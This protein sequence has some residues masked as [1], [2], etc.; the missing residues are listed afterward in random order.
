[1]IYRGE[2]GYLELL[3]DV[4]ALGVDI[5]DR[6]GVGCRAL[7]DA[8]W[9]IEKG[10]PFSTVRPAA[11]RLAF[12]EFW[13]FLRGE[14]QTKK[15]EDKGVM[16]WKGNTSRE[17]LDQRGLYREPEGDMGL[18]YGFQFRH[19]GAVRFYHEPL[20]PV[21][22]GGYDQLENLIK[23]LQDDRY[24]RRHYVTFWNPRDS[25][26]MSL[27]PCWH[28][29]QFVVL[30]NRDGED[31]LH[32]KLVN[33]SLDATFGFSFAVQQ[34]RLYQMCVAKLLGINLGT[35]SADLSHVHI[36]HNQLAY[37]GEMLTR[38]FGKAGEV[39]I[40]KDLNSVSDIL[41]M[42]WDDIEV[43]GLEVNKTPFV[44]PRPPMAV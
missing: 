16:F 12:E 3:E 10:F 4:L 8:R 38:D 24:G 37:V 17:F 35:L 11:L 31:E 29:H 23:S 21:V 25:H 1:M 5:P 42:Q 40:K 2:V 15:L 13:F 32:L 18:A 26:K 27:T 34:Y 22:L 6:T 41:D 20:E 7:F 44:T 43:V 14:T 9:S 33:R 36:Y 28:S 30:P 39:M 19:F